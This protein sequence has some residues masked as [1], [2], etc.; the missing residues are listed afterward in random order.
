[1]LA[2]IDYVAGGGV[3]ERIGAASK[4]F[5]ALEKYNIGASLAQLDRGSEASETAADYDDPFAHSVPPVAEQV[6]G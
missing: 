3:E 2:V 1:M 4:V 6:D 5:S